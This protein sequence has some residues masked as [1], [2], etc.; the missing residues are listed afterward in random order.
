[1]VIPGLFQLFN[2]GNADISGAADGNV[3]TFNAASG[4]W[5]PAAGGGGALTHVDL[6]AASVTVTDGSPSGSG[7]NLLDFASFSAHFGHLPKQFLVQYDV[8]VTVPTGAVYGS[9]DVVSANSAGAAEI[10]VSD[11]IPFLGIA[12]GPLNAEIGL[13]KL[14]G[15]HVAFDGTTT[16]KLYWGL[17]GGGGITLRQLS[18]TILA[19]W[20]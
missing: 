10:D 7:M 14:L 3:L 20:Y 18:A 5:K 11:V 17:T 19:Y 9:L 16:Y 8:Q 6:S 1:M 12:G 2:Q 13:T 4:K 15:P